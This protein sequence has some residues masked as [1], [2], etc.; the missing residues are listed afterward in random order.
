MSF[1]LI[2]LRHHYP[3]VVSILLAV[4]IAVQAAS[5]AVTTFVLQRSDNHGVGRPPVIRSA[6]A[7]VAA[8]VDAHLFGAIPA[9]PVSAEQTS[10]S[11]SPLV[12]TG[13]IALTDPTRG[14]AIVGKDRLTTRTYLVGTMVAEGVTLREVYTDHVVVDRGGELETVSMPKSS[15]LLTAPTKVLTAAVA[16]PSANTAAHPEPLIPPEIREPLD[17]EN[18]RVGTA[19]KETALTDH[20]VFRGLVL[21]PGPDP[22]ILAQMGLKPGDIVTGVNNILIDL[23]NLALLRKYLASGGKIV[24]NINRPQEGPINLSL[25]SAPYQGL[26]SNN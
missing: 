17:Y 25:D 21:Q 5:I 13:T 24:L 19:F 7:T 4:G 12:L 9:A 2:R 26:V 14:F 15:L 20:D 23:N 18:A 3:R 11:S 16:A 8:V 22:S 10:V 6:P 1:G